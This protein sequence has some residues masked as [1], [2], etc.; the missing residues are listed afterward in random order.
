MNTDGI[1]SSRI[2]LSVLALR[3]TLGADFLH[4]A[5]ATS[6]QVT[7][8]D[9]AS[10]NSHTCLSANDCNDKVLVRQVNFN[11]SQSGA[12]EG[13]SLIATSTVTRT[14]TLA[15]QFD[16]GSNMNRR[17]G[18][19]LENDNRVMLELRKGTETVIRRR[20]APSERLPLDTVE[21]RRQRNP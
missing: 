13:F 11:C 5:L 7:R 15:P 4:L 17:P 21:R 14:S 8:V 6:R 2:P 19:R 18:F 16:R 10:C 20:A 9:T 3:Q 12:Q 1:R